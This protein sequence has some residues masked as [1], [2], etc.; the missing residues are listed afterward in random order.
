MRVKDVTDFHFSEQSSCPKAGHK[1]GCHLKKKL[2]T[3][4][5]DAWK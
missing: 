3:K 1:E 5:V 2:I 4:P